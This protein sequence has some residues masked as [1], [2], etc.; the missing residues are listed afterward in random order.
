LTPASPAIPV[1]ETPR[2]RLRGHLVSDFEAS[3]AMWADPEVVRFVGGKPY[4]REDSWGRFL[5]YAGHWQVMGFGYW[6]V[7]E[8]AGG[9][10][11]GEVGFSDFKREIEPRLEGET[12]IGWLLAAAAHRKGYATEAARSALSWVGAERGTN[13]TVC[14]IDADH[15]ASIRVADKLGFREA[16]RTTY[17]DR[18]TILFRRELKD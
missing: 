3:A 12:E 6:L 10:F 4:T 9:G 5:R 8:K 18:P 2:L 7:E 16:L 1:L 15:K 11:V 13:S 17:K 14:I